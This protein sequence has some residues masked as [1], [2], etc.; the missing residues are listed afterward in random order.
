MSE[1]NPSYTASATTVGGRNGHIKTSD[2]IIDVESRLP[3]ELGGPGGDYTNP[4]MLFAAGYS[5][6]YGSA[7]KLVAE[8]MNAGA[9]PE[10]ISVTADVTL[11]KDPEDGGFKLAVKISLSIKGLDEDKVK[12]IAEKA[13]Q[14]CPYSKATRGNIEVEVTTK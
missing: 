9:K 6:C 13:H 3:K 5:S 2:G 12:D 1:N 10:D 7:V 14:V 11:M 4:E 8:K